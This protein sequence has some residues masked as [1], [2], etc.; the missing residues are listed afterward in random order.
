G[1]FLLDRERRIGCGGRFLDAAHVTGLSRTRYRWVVLAAGTAAQAS[2][3]AVLIGL[4]V[5]APA[6]QDRYD[7]SLSEV[8]IAFSSV[9]LGPILTLLPWGLLADR[10]GERIV[11]AGGL[12]L[13]GGLVAAAGWAGSFVGL[14][15]VLAVAGGAGASVNAASGRAVMQW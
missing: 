3:S 14:L 12:A 15:A 10:V 9:W 8:G 6:L 13:C 2:F 5:L 4:P 7:I 11:L 1:P